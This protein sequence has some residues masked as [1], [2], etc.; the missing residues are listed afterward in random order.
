M[1]LLRASS[2]TKGKV[3]IHDLNGSLAGLLYSR[4]QLFFMTST[5]LFFKGKGSESFYVLGFKCES[6]DSGGFG[7]SCGRS[8]VRF[9]ALAVEVGGGL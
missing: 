2:N 7:G 5:G 6:E 1:G 3:D 8:R 9:R 4:S